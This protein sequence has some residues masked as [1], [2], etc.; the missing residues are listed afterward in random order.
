MRARTLSVA[1]VTAVFAL[2]AACTG[3]DAVLSTPA[4]SDGGTPATAAPTCSASAP[5]AGGG[6]CVDGFCCNAA[7]TGTCEACNVAGKE[8]TCSPVTGTPRHGAC[9]GNPTGTCAGSCDGKNGAQCTYPTTACG[10]P[11]CAGGKATLPATCKAGKCPAQETQDCT[12][13]LGCDKDSCL[14]VKQVAGGRTYACAV[15]TDKRL[16][17]WGDNDEGQLGLVTSAPDIV[18]TPTVVPNL[19]DVEM[20]AAAGGATCVLLGDKTVKCMGGNARGELGT[21]AVDSSKHT[22]TL[23]AGLTDVVFI[24]GASGSHFCAITTS[25]T[26]KC[27]GSNYNGQLGDGT[28]TPTPKAPV[29]VCQP[30]DM[31][32]TPSSGATFVAGGDNHT[33]AAFAGGN[34]ACWGGNSQGQLGQTPVPAAGGAPNP[35]PTFITGLVATYLTAGN[36]VTCAASGGSAKCFGS[37]GLGILGNASQALSNPVPQSVCTKADCSAGLTG[38]TAVSTYDESACAVAGGTVKCWGTNSGGALGDGTASASQGFAATTTIATGAVSVASI[39]P[40][41]MAIVVDRAN[42]SLRCW[43]SESGS[44]CG[45]GL[46]P[47][48]RTTPVS[49]LW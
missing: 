20:V 25:G 33:C 32:C 40:M 8:G 3:E 11:S 9:D 29:T 24:G 31:G 38:V 46:P 41:N 1:L 37:N 49:P 23:V 44:L 43:G 6:L 47:G 36:G 26:V 17:C 18:A 7:C 5:C 30:G 22:P 27:W 42:R 48:D 14:G 21:G 45:T 2:V 15:M 35:V 10:T 13:G 4:D 12:T 28:M 39:G 19:L 34:V 16:R